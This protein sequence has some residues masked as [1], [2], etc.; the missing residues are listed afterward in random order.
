MPTT[1][2]ESYALAYGSDVINGEKRP[3]LDLSEVSGDNAWRMNTGGLL[4]GRT[5]EINV[6]Y[7]QHRASLAGQGRSIQEHI[8]EKFKSLAEAVGGASLR[9]VLLPRA[10]LW[11]DAFLAN[12]ELGGEPV[13]HY[14]LWLML[15]GYY[16]MP[17]FEAGEEALNRLIG[18][19]VEKE[20]TCF[21]RT[22]SVPPD[23]SFVY[24]HCHVFSLAI[25]PNDK[26]V[27]IL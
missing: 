17:D 7:E 3:I 21:Q 5:T 16:G 20:A 23:E 4:V 9:G 26:S 12:M 8:F 19:D 25:L 15:R 13:N 27:V 11:K 24:T 10:V 2:K 14:N 6:A 18:R 1:L 22:Q